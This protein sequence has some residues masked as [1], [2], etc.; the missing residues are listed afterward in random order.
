MEP[1]SI[2]LPG[3]GIRVHGLDWGDQAAPALV[4]LLH[5]VA[6]NARIWDAVA[7]RLRI[8]LG[9]AH[10]VVALDGRDGGLTEHPP[11][12]YGP[13]DFGADLKSVHDA[14]GG[15][16]LTL[17][18]H[19]R[20]A[21]LAAWFAERHPERIRRLVLVDPARLTFQTEQ[22]SEAF[23]DRVREAL[24]PWQNEEA[25][26][27]WGRAHDPEGDWNEPRRRGFLANYHRLP[28]GSLVG[29]LPIDA[30]THLRRP[31]M[32]DPVGPL[33]H[34]VAC[35]TLLLVG[36]RQAQQRIADKLTYAEGI[37]D[38]RVVSLPASHFIHTDLPD[39]AAEEIARFAAA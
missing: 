21:W 38:C 3:S 37:P 1:Q 9:H 31:A 33:L 11:S 23:F 17:V 19:S 13:E 25:A 32:E 39:Q 26:L 27:A 29:H 30:V 15:R 34:Q 14:L 10:Q 6:G 12:G 24:G 8:H 20:G 4:L 16:P 36:T 7:T 28:D 18:G 22:A 2:W 5:G 35:P